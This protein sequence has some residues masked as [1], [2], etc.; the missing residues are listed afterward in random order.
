MP[1]A[2]YENYENP[3]NPQENP[4]EKKNHRIPVENP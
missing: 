3:G 4:E 1:L 2:N